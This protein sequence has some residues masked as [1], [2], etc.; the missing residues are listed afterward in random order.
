MNYTNDKTINYTDFV[1]N[2]KQN[3]KV[4][5]DKITAVSSKDV[6]KGVLGIIKNLAKIGL[7]VVKVVFKTVGKVVTAVFWVLDEGVTFIAYK[8][9]IKFLKLDSNKQ[10]ETIKK[11]VATALVTVV[12]LGVTFVGLSSKIKT[13]ESE[14]SV[15]AMASEDT[16]LN[17]RNIQVEFEEESTDNTEE[18]TKSIETKIAPR[19]VDKEVAT[20]VVKKETRINSKTEFIGTIAFKS[21]IGEVDPGYM[22]TTNIRYEESGKRMIKEVDTYGLGEFTTV[23]GKRY[24]KDFTDYVKEVDNEFYNEYFDGVGKPGTTTFTTGWYNASKTEAE[25]FKGLQFEYIYKTYIQPTVDTI[26]EEYNLDLMSSKASQEF[27]FSTANQYGK[28]GT[29]TLFE[30]ANITS[31]MTEKEIIEAV[32]KEKINSLGVYT[33]TEKWGYT[34]KDRE[35]FKTRAENELKQFL[36]LL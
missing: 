32:Q 27:I 4:A 16:S 14:T 17:A 23:K 6:G 21:A 35:S 5:V 24:A 30:K 1:E 33:Y 22:G 19:T 25:K 20:E 31:D 2:K 15:V 34:D 36:E 26:K 3:K 18:N 28:K 13:L 11:I 9:Q 12:G 10:D 7:N 8:L 29:L